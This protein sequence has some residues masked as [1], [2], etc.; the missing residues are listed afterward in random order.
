VFRRT[1]GSSHSPY[2]KKQVLR[3]A[4]DDKLNKDC[5]PRTLGNRREALHREGRCSE[6]AKKAKKAKKAAD[7]EGCVDLEFSPQRAQ[8]NTEETK[9]LTAK[10]AKKS[11]E[12]RKEEAS[13]AALN[14]LS[15]QVKFICGAL[16]SRSFA[17]LR[18]R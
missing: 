17:A 9:H 18:V 12:E 4:Q 13:R 8:G 16:K 1:A 14:L 15:K 2:K 7:P 10:F 3:C 5:E 11:R 6:A